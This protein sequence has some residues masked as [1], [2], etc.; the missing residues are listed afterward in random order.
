MSSTNQYI[1]LSN[2]LFEIQIGPQGELIV[3]IGVSGLM[4]PVPCFL[5][6]S[7]GDG[8]EHHVAAGY[9]MIQGL[10]FVALDG[11]VVGQN[12][13]GSGIPL[14]TTL[15]QNVRIGANFTGIIDEF[16][17]NSRFDESIFQR[18]EL[19]RGD[20]LLVLEHFDSLS[21][22]WNQELG[23]IS[24]PFTYKGITTIPLTLEGVSITDSMLLERTDSFQVIFFLK[25]IFGQYREIFH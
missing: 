6:C 23:F 15:P 17:L 25:V 4:V 5:T 18:V 20:D 9:D 3:L 1:A 16:H 13:L 12:V 21:R 22:L 10:F 2:N 7:L 19:N 8:L 11:E 14:A 24:S